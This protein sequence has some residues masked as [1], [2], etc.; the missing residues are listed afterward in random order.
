M[1]NNMIH[2]LND[3]DNLVK[4]QLD[5]NSFSILKKD[6]IGN[7]IKKLEELWEDSYKFPLETSK[8]HEE[9][10]KNRFILKEITNQLETTNSKY[11]LYMKQGRKNALNKEDK[12]ANLFV[13]YI[14][15]QHPKKFIPLIKYIDYYK[16]KQELNNIALAEENNNIVITI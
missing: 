7:A 16:I 8:F 12:K 10:D 9:I 13:C 14:N 6:E 4:I 1:D 5:K 2:D 11:F 3:M 15:P